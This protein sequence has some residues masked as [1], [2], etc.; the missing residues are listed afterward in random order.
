MASSRRCEDVPDEVR[1]HYGEL[2][3][4]IRGHQFRYYVLDSPTVTDGEFDVLLRELQGI[5]D[6]Y[7]SL[8]TPDSPTQRVGGAFSTDFTAVDHLER[9]LSLDN[10][11]NTEDLRAWAERVHKE[12]GEDSHFLCELKIDG[13]A[14]NLLYEDGRLVRALTR[15]DGRTGED[16]TLNVRTI[17]DSRSG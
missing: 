16:V 8:V 9:L 10:V 14:L 7:P 3:E 2:A 15:G 5:E 13:L 12:I 1:T 11:F 4:Q 6:K 17:K